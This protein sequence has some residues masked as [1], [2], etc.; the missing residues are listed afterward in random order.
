MVLEIIRG[1]ILESPHRH[2][3]FGINTEGFND[4]GFAGLVASRYW[5]DLANTGPKELGEVLSLEADGRVFHAIV[6]HSLSEQNGWEAAAKTVHQALDQ[7]DLPED[8]VISCVW[9]GRGFI[10]MMSGANS[11]EM[12]G[13]MTLAKPKINIYYI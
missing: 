3:I 10:G 4:A 12:V 9:I 6:C 7:L 5:P 8:E 2:I 11:V 13:A 1:D